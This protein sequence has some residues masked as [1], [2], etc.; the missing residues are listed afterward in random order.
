[1]ENPIEKSAKEFLRSWSMGTMTSAQGMITPRLVEFLQANTV[2]QS[3]YTLYRGFK[4]PTEQEFQDYFHVP[5][6]SLR[7]GSVLSVMQKH[8][9]SWTK[10]ERLAR[11]FADPSYDSQHH[12]YLKFT[13]LQNLGHKS[14]DFLGLGVLVKTVVPAR[15]VLVDMTQVN[16]K[17]L[18][19][20]NSEEEVVTLGGK[21]SVKVL[22]LKNVTVDP[23]LNAMEDDEEVPVPKDSIGGLIHDIHKEENFIFSLRKKYKT[24]LEAYIYLSHPNNTQEYW[25]TAVGLCFLYV[26][27]NRSER[28]KDWFLKNYDLL[29]SHTTFRMN[30][31]ALIKMTLKTS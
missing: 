13:E 4:F 25:D 5:W 6:D 31:P 27:N 17:L 30:T 18:F 21:Y 19:Y 12:S 9:T 26:A 24:E 20:G 2:H 1:M 10:K 29:S 16:S 8:F 14:G 23:D 7:V 3:S 28:I 22:E 15:R 11:K